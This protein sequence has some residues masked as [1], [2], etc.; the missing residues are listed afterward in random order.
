METSKQP[1]NRMA[2]RG[3]RPVEPEVI[4]DFIFEAESIFIAVK[5]IS[6]RPLN[7]VRAE[8]DPPFSGLG[9]SQPIDKLPIF[10]RN[11]FLAPGKEIRTLVDTSRAFFDREEPTHITITV[12]YRDF[13]GRD[14]QVELQHDLEIYQKLITHISK[15]R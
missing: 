9:G 4:L 2:D 12:A 6:A 1:P 5:N 15:D 10:N 3:R 11:Y 8:F 13:R 14:F 7:F